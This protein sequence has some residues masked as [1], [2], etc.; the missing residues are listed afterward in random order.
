MNDHNR[1]SSGGD[2]LKD[3]IQGLSVVAE[4]LNTPHAI[5]SPAMRAQL[6]AARA[7][8]DDALERAATSRS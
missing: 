6:A 5:V 7:L 8:V 4:H 1:I 2:P 3:A